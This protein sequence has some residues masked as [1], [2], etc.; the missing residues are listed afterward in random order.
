VSGRFSE[1]KQAIHKHTQDKT[2]NEPKVKLR[3]GMPPVNLDEEVGKS[4]G[5]R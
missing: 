5:P 3:T 2:T 1:S 4:T